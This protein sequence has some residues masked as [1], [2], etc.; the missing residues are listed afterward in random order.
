MRQCQ[1][2][3]MVAVYLRVCGAIGIM[4]LERDV[5]LG[6]SPRVRSH[7]DESMYAEDGTRSISACAEPSSKVMNA[8][9]DE[10]VY[11]RVC[12]AI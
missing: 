11:L 2:A 9:K 8:D 6:L 5:H 10:E 4:S 12:G 7:P 3:L 1:N